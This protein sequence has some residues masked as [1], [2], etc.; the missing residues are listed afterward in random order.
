MARGHVLVNLFADKGVDN[1]NAHPASCF[2]GV[3]DSW[4]AQLMHG[5]KRNDCDRLFCVSQAGHERRRRTVAH[6]T[7]HQRL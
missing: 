5:L 2:F 1:E 4:G 7:I 6:T 3:V